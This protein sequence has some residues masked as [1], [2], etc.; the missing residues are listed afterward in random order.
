MREETPEAHETYV[1]RP[2]ER[3]DSTSQFI[4]ILVIKIRIDLELVEWKMEH[5][6][7]LCVML[8]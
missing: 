7:A 8:A 5:K 3:L 4:P 6:R 2:R 1:V